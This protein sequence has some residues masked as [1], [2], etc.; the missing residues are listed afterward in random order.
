MF[1]RRHPDTLRWWMILLAATAVAASAAT[2]AI[3]ADGTGTA[4]SSCCLCD[5]C[6]LPAA[7][8]HNEHA[9]VARMF[10]HGD[11]IDNR[12]IRG[13]SSSSL[14]CAGLHQLALSLDTTSSSRTPE[15]D[16]EQ[17]CTTLQ[18]QNRESCCAAPPA[19]QQKQQQQQNHRENFFLC[20]LCHSGKYPGNPKRAAVVLQI[21]EPEYV[22]V[23][24]RACRQLRVCLLVLLLGKQD[25]SWSVS[26]IHKS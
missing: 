20:T 1:P 7:V 17:Q 18:E 23:C 24:L 10:G 22:R 8:H 11:S 15:N 21:P 6:A 9:D 4:A 13:G 26:H 3:P 12:S 25:P 19:Q 2:L 14:S 5:H 16:W